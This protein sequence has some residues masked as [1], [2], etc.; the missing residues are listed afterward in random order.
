MFLQESETENTAI[1]SRPWCKYTGSNLFGLH[2]TTTNSQQQLHILQPSLCTATFLLQ[3]LRASSCLSC[4]HTFSVPDK[5]V[6][7]LNCVYVLERPFKKHTFMVFILNT[8]ILLTVLEEIGHL[9]IMPIRWCSYLCLSVYITVPWA[10]DWSCSD[11][12]WFTGNTCLTAQE[13]ICHCPSRNTIVKWL[14]YCNL[15]SLVIYSTTS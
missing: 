14:Y 2:T 6:I 3:G 1:D 11:S 10:C 9:V 13:K 15:L 8:T 5:A 7:L 4:V 12:L